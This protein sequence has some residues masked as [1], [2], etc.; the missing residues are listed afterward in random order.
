MVDYKNLV[1]EE[2]RKSFETA[3]STQASSLDP[4]VVG[5]LLGNTLQAIEGLT[6][7]DD[8]SAA[9]TSRADELHA[10]AAANRSSPE[11]SDVCIA[12]GA[13]RNAAAAVW[14]ADDERRLATY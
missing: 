5:E 3:F 11:W 8:V 9:L 10:F 7:V 1:T 2:F 4:E 12:M 14:R 13:V 6:V